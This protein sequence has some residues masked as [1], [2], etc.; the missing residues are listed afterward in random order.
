[1]YDRNYKAFACKT[2]ADE[3]GVIPTLASLNGKF[4]I[5]CPMQG[6]LR[7]YPVNYLGVTDEQ[8]SVL[9]RAGLGTVGKL[10]DFMCAGYDITA[11]RDI[12]EN[13]ANK[14][15]GQLLVASYARLDDDEQLDFWGN[16]LDSMRRVA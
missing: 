9:S 6:E 3:I 7:S 2:V 16:V 14:I 10:A 8:S 11:F 5:V 15:K 13:T 1:M 4:N 12:G